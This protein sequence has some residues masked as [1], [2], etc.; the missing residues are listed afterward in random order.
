MQSPAILQKEENEDK[1]HVFARLYLMR[2]GLT[3]GQSD[4]DA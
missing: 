4:E 1:R 3:E 2:E